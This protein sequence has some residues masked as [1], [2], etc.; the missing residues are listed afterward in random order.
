M[1]SL[2][3]ENETNQESQQRRFSDATSRNLRLELLLEHPVFRAA[4]RPKPPGLI[5]FCSKFT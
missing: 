2:E 5:E 1:D 3:P 4:Y